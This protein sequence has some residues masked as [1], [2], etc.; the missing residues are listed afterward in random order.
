[1][2]TAIELRA[3]SARWRGRALIVTRH[4]GSPRASVWLGAWVLA[5]AVPLYSKM[6]NRMPQR[7]L[8]NVGIL[9]FA[10][11]LGI[12]YFLFQ[13]GIRLFAQGVIFFL[14]TSIFSVMVVA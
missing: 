12:F 2:V 14:W 3:H 6:A 7:R 10:A 4:T 8:I 13:L 11:N 5:V 9:Y 1:M